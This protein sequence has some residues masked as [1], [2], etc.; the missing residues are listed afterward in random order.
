[1]IKNIKNLPAG[2]KFFAVMM[3]VYAGLSIFNYPYLLMISQ[4]LLKSFEEIVPILLL[5]FFV[6]FLMNYFIKPAV[7]KKHLG[8]DSG[9]KGWLYVLIGSVFIFGPPYVI[10]PILNEL[11]GH[12]MKSSLIAVFLNNRNVQPAFLPVMAF[13][14]GW[15]YTIVVSVYVVIFAILTGLVIGRVV[16]DEEILN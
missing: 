5:A 13:Y 3:L 4:N 11:K 16:S 1:M 14:F 10:L 2:V 6:V 15:Q 12:G 7:I 9:L 8:Q